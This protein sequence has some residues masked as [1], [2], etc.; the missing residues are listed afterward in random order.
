MILFNEFQKKTQK[1]PSEQI[2]EA[3]TLMKKYFE[4]KNNQ[5]NG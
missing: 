2:E 5:T 3:E 1:T 4:Q